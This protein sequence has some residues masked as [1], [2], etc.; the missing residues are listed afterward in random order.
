M[1]RDFLWF[2]TLCGDASVSLEASGISCRAFST[3]RRNSLLF[4]G[5]ISSQLSIISA[6]IQSIIQTSNEVAVVNQLVEMDVNSLDKNNTETE[7][8]C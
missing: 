8:V 7:Q 1:F 4:T 5:R 3:E 6:T 2:V